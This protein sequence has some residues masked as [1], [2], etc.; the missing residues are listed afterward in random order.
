M[1]VP[2][3]LFVPMVVVLLAGPLAAPAAAATSQGCSGSVSTVTAPG[4]PLE[5]VTLPG[6]GG[7]EERPFQLFWAQPVSWKAQTYQAPTSGTWRLAVEDPS[8]LFALGELVTGH[9]DGLNGTFDS[10]PGVTSFSNSFI[11]SSTEPVTL[12]GRYT[13]DVTVAGSQGVRCTAMLSVRV[14]D[15][16]ERNPLFWLALIQLVAG[17]ALLFV[18]GLSKFTRPALVRPNERE[19]WR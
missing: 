8:W 5:S 2:A 6:P 19:Q 10:G 14:I 3:T 17:V 18:Y 1:K 16:P 13:I 9:S 4:T 11:P 12:P 7:T 15:R